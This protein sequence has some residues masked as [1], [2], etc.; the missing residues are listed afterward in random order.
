MSDDPTALIGLPLIS[1][2]ASLSQFGSD[3]LGS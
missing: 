3:P 2:T 1:L